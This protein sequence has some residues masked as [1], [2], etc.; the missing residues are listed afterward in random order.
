MYHLLQ[1]IARAYGEYLTESGKHREAGISKNQYFVYRQ[2]ILTP[3]PGP[4][5]S[6]CPV[7]LPAGGSGSL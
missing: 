1:A 2:P 7:R 3:P 4:S 6:P 5:P